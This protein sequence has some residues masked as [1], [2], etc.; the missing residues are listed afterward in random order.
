MKKFVRLYYRCS[1]NVC[2]WAFLS[3]IGHH[4]AGGGSG[5]FGSVFGQRHLLRRCVRD[6]QRANERGGEELSCM[7]GLHH[8][9]HSVSCV[10]LRLMAS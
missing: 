1:F 5:N 7:R 6:R 4:V 10:N 3:L 9:L 8:C 2:L